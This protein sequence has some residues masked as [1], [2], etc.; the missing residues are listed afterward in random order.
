M[1]E[2]GTSKGVDGRVDE[3]VAHKQHNMQ[4]KQ[5]SVTL[6]VRVL[7]AY[8][9]DDEVDKKRGPTHHKCPK[10]DG[11]SQGPSHAVATPPLM[12]ALPTVTGGQ[13][14]NVSGMDACQ[15]EHV[16]IEEAD[17]HQ[18]DEKEDNK[19]D[20]DELGGKEPDHEHS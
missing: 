5:R 3:G 9:D 2:L 4:L 10:Q 12:P 20:L 6:A 8:H 18:R 15:H 17:N 14:S 1:S 13:S 7:G 11:E 19:A 16:N